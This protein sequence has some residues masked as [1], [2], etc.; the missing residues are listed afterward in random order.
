MALFKL[1]TLCFVIFLLVINVTSDMV[2]RGQIVSADTRKG[3]ALKSVRCP[4][5]IIS[6]VKG[7]AKPP[8]TT[9]SSSTMRSSRITKAPS[10]TEPPGNSDDESEVHGGPANKKQKICEDNAN[11]EPV[12]DCSS[13]ADTPALASQTEESECT[14]EEEEDE[15]ETADEDDNY[16]NTCDEDDEGDEDE[17][18]EED[19]DND[20]IEIDD[21]E[22]F[23]ELK[24]K[25]KK[26][27]A[28][29]VV[30]F[31]DSEADF[32]N[33]NAARGLLN[34]PIPTFCSHR[35]GDTFEGTIERIDR[36]R[37]NTQLKNAFLKN[38]ATAETVPHPM[39][40]GR[41]VKQLIL[42]PVYDK[43]NPS[44]MK[45]SYGT[46]THNAV[47]EFYN[48]KPRSRPI[49][50][51]T[52][53]NLEELME[54][55]SCPGCDDIGHVIG[56]QV[57]GAYDAKN[58]FLQDPAANFNM[59]GFEVRQFNFL[60]RDEGRSIDYI[61]EYINEGNVNGYVRYKETVWH[62]RY[63]AED[64]FSGELHFTMP[65]PR[66]VKETYFKKKQEAIASRKYAEPNL[67]FEK[68]Y[69]KLPNY[70]M[71]YN[72]DWYEM[73][74]NV[75]G[76]CKK[77]GYDTPDFE[78]KISRNSDGHI[79]LHS[80]F[81]NGEKRLEYLYGQFE[82]EKL[83]DVDQNKKW[84]DTHT[85]Q[86][87]APM[88]LAKKNALPGDQYGHLLSAC[89]GGSF[90][91]FNMY[92]QNEEVNMD[93]S[94]FELGICRKVR[95][96]MK[97]DKVIVEAMFNFTYASSGVDNV[98]H[99]RPESTNVCLRIK[100]EKEG[101][102]RAICFDLPNPESVLRPYYEEFAR[103]NQDNFFVETITMIKGQDKD[104][105]F[106]Q[107]GFTIPRKEVHNPRNN[108]IICPMCKQTSKNNFA[109]LSHLRVHNKYKLKGLECDIPECMF[110]TDSKGVL[111]RHMKH[112]HGD[113]KS[114]EIERRECDVMRKDG[115]KCTFY[116]Y[117]VKEIKE[118][119][120]K[121]TANV[122]NFKF[123]CPVS[124][125]C[126]FMANIK[127][128]L[129]AHEETHKKSEEQSC[130]GDPSQAPPSL[131]GTQ[132]DKEEMFKCPIDDC[133]A[134]WPIKKNLRNFVKA[135]SCHLE[136][137]HRKKDP[138]QKFKKSE[139]KQLAEEERIKDC[140]GERVTL[141]PCE[142]GCLKIFAGDRGLKQHNKAEHSPKC[143]DEASAPAG[144]MKCPVKGCTYC[145]PTI[146][147]GGKNAKK[148]ICPAH[149]KRQ[150]NSHL[151]GTK[152]KEY[153]EAHRKDR[154]YPNNPEWTD[155]EKE[156]LKKYKFKPSSGDKKNFLQVEIL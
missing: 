107:Y 55:T 91:D 90:E 53:A 76:D 72:V 49:D 109:L 17:Q 150:L 129:R 70:I 114:D 134:K 146:N 128:K 89:L 58:L 118:H 77:N 115:K 75:R 119:K 120:D 45:Y 16:D 2:I 66:S 52:K 94:N 32:K 145:L 50:L 38:Q 61:V 99:P 71:K 51:E 93:M 46:L 7:G 31:Y 135:I 102:W 131:T 108:N 141:K 14:D 78:K 26:I 37:Q 81:S 28:G 100:T 39:T 142:K 126:P 152:D 133:N 74:L 117:T 68:H 10:T 30:N 143:V 65:N 48:S 73:R 80:I 19:G 148:E 82:V 63:H 155:E 34:M 5:N 153:Y 62:I 103:F 151:V 95:E 88:K 11:P 24:E 144:Y 105:K 121:H 123:D 136:N 124:T 64:G 42:H 8:G 1:V 106:A 97:E 57:G 147:Q 112:K 54:K 40:D 138:N 84:Y 122:N 36:E 154:A 13:R 21:D 110:R 18:E 125:A 86:T 41:I 25:L 130:K 22:N 98:K 4:G 111:K 35:K 43:S 59:R 85:W 44:M 23:D 60:V 6:E 139:L 69:G 27:N 149:L 33:D 92:P 113:P 12:Q 101:K 127:S 132:P 15:E 3:A 9:G 47:S 56:Y 140:K 116:A 96:D 87:V 156:I 67:E 20:L 29:V 79:T 104:D 137:D 83:L